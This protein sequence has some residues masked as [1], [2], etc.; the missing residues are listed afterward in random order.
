[1]IYVANRVALIQQLHAVPLHKHNVEFNVK[2]LDI[3][4]SFLVQLHIKDDIC[5]LFVL[6]H[7]H[8]S[9]VLL[10][11]QVKLVITGVLVTLDKQQLQD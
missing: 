9:L 3:L 10:T 6:L 8:T 7:V 4:V 2:F 1:M 5:R 11:L